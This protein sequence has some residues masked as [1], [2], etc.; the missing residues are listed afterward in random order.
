MGLKAAREERDNARAMLANDRDHGQHK[1]TLKAQKAM[2]S[3]VSFEGIAREW[4]QGRSKVWSES[5]AANIMGRLGRIAGISTRLRSLKTKHFSEPHN[6]SR[7][8]LV[9][10]I[11]LPPGQVAMG[12][13][14]YSERLLLWTTSGYP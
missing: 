3:G 4:H 7:D 13:P 1:Q 14:R 12:P 6:P 10:P 11:V 8:F 9:L 5:Y 2:I